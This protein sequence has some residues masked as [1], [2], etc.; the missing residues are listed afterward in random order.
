MSVRLVISPA[1]AR[2]LDRL[3]A[4]LLDKDPTAAIRAGEVLR[5]ALQTL[6]EFPLRS[7]LVRGEIRELNAPFGRSVYVIRHRVRGEQVIVTRI[8]HGRERR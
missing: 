3:E 2:D 1:A 8:F 7:R 4:W 6:T 5:A